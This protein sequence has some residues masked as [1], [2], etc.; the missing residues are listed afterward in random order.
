MLAPLRILGL[1]GIWHRPRLEGAGRNWHHF[2]QACQQHWPKADF[3]VAQQWLQPWQHTELHGYMAETLARYDDGM[4]TFIV[5]YSLGGLA[6]FA[7]AE[8]FQRSPIVGCLGVC[9]PLRLA[10]W[11]GL[12]LEPEVAYPRLNVA[13]L[14]DPVVPPWLSKHAA[15]PRSLLPIDHLAAFL[16]TAI[17]AHKALEHF[18]KTLKVNQVAENYGGPEETRT[19]T[20]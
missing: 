16:L 20:P 15:I 19:L 17:P 10:G 11:Y 13:G 14:L 9:A 5:G 4:P 1:V 7:L 2:Q 8:Q 12:K 3:V 6:G 18:F